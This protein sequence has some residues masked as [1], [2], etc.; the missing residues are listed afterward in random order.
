MKRF[1]VGLLLALVAFGAFGNGIA[2]AI[3]F[4]DETVQAP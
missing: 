1:G 2:Q 4:P 3:D